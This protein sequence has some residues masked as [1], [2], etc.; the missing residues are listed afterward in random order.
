[1]ADQSI[2]KRKAEDDASEDASESHT[3]EGNEGAGS[4]AG[5][6]KKDEMKKKLRDLRMRR[7]EAH[8]LNRSEVVEEDRRNKLP[9]NWEAKQERAKWILEK[10]EAKRQAA[11][12]GLEYDRVRNLQMTAEEA[13]R[14]DRKKQSK[15]PWEN[16]TIDFTQTHQRHYQRLT[17]ELKPD[18]DTYKEHKD[19]L[20]ERAYPSA[21]DLD[22]GLDASAK[23]APGAADRLAQAVEKHI[24]KR[25]RHSRRRAFDEDDDIDYINENNMRYN[26]MV[27]KFYGKYTAGI[28]QDLERGTAL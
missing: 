13:A 21:Q 14:R 17:K 4:A 9:A 2:K 28:K 25:A 10:E 6:S 8:S 7:T 19:Q 23:I 22:Y 26:K 27:H 3:N 15:T 20:G 5:L 16:G 12:Q 18:L 11:E 1:M 24:E